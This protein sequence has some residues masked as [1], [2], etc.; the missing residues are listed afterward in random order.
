MAEAPYE[1]WKNP[2]RV[3]MDALLTGPPADKEFLLVPTDFP[4]NPTTMWM[5]WKELLDYAVTR[6][7]YEGYADD[8]ALVWWREQYLNDCLDR[9]GWL[10]LSR[11]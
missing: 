11:P 2:E 3:R 1:P 6:C 8:R 10:L 5:D 7:G 4:S 9:R